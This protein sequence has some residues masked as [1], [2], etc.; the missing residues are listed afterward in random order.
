VKEFKGVI[1]GEF[2]VCF[3]IS[4]DAYWWVSPLVILIPPKGAVLGSI[5]ELSHGGFNI[6]SRFNP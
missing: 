2:R 1:H 4:L 3:E 6:G 5:P